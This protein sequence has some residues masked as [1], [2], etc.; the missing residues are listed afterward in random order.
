MDCFNEW[1]RDPRGIENISKWARNYFTVYFHFFK[2]TPEAV[3]FYKRIKR[4]IS[5]SNLFLINTMEEL[6][7]FF[8]SD[9]YRTD[10]C[11]LENRKEE[12]KVKHDFYKYRIINT[13]A[14]FL[15]TA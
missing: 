4:Y 2:K 6:V 8:E 3:K 11:L 14:D 12:I 13:M 1:L 7:G 5:E 9:Q 15:E 10:L